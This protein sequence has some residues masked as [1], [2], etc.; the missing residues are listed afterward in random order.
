MESARPVASSSARVARAARDSHRSR[1][2]PEVRGGS[3]VQPAEPST[4]ADL[5]AQRAE[6]LATAGC[7]PQS[8]DR[9]AHLRTVEEPF[10]AAQ[11][12]RDSSLRERLLQRGRLGVDTEQH[13]DI[14]GPGCRQRGSRARDW[15]PAWPPRL[16]RRRPPPWAPDR[17]ASASAGR[18][19]TVR[20]TA[21]PPRSPRWP[22]PRSPGYSGSTA[23][24]VPRWHRG[25]RHE[26]R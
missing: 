11:H 23:R 15:L 5:G 16:R 18:G 22:S 7:A 24:D 6:Q 26:S 25:R 19:S 9:L 20:R 3:G 13:G 1:T 8:G 4:R 17:K 12:D 14:P 21:Q 2:A 10:G